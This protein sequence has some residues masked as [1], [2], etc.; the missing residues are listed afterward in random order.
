MNSMNIEQARFNMIE[1]QVR[2]WDVLDD[3]VLEVLSAT[4]REDFVPEQYTSMAFADISIPLAQEQCMMPP[5]LEGKLL[6]SLAIEPDDNILEIGIGSAY[7]TACLARLGSKVH[8][9][10]LYNNFTEQARDLLSRHAIN[11]VSLE[12]ADAAAGLD[13]EQ[14]FDVIAVTGS[15]PVLHQEFHAR[16]NSGGRLFVIVGKPPIMQALLITRVDEQEWNQES[17][18]ETAIPALQ[19]APQAEIFK[20]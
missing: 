13:T 19:N 14:R 11:N 10:D 15:L 7:V 4:P 5:K 12:T 18:F 16:L 9:V 1:Q 6:Q 17:L 8:S 3:R 20:F 2:P